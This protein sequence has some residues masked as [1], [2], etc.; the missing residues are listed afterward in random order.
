MGTLPV[1]WLL[2]NV[3]EALLSGSNSRRGRGREEGK[4]RRKVGEIRRERERDRREQRV[5]V[6]VR[7]QWRLKDQFGKRQSPQGLGLLV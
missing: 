7:I 3:G 4:G 5:P 6:V 1:L 2:Q